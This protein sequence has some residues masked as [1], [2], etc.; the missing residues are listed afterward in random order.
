MSDPKTF[1]ELRREVREAL[2][3]RAGLSAAAADDMELAVGELLSNVH[4][5]AYRGDVGPMAVAVL[6]SRLAVSVLVLD[7]GNAT[8]VPRVPAESPAP[9]SKGGRGLYLVGV[10]ADR[11]LMCVN[12]KTGGL[13]VRITKYFPLLAAAA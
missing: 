1:G 9:T 8:M 10:L 13:T 12:K 11:I 2:I 4:E 6:R 7:H 3:L 5:H